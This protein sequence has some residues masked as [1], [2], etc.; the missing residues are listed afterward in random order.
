MLP[1][2]LSPQELQEYLHISNKTAYDLIKKDSFPSF[3][4][5][6]GEWKVPEDELIEWVHKQTRKSKRT[7]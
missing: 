4:I 6:G 3:R 2:L 1:R 7:V 5:G